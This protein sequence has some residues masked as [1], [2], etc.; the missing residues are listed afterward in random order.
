MA[1]LLKVQLFALVAAVCIASVAGLKCQVGNANK[2]TGGKTAIVSQT[3]AASEKTCTD[4][5]GKTTEFACFKSV[6][7]TSAAGK[8]TTKVTTWACIDKKK[9]KNVKNG[10]GSATHGMTKGVCCLTDN[11]NN[12]KSENCTHGNDAATNLAS[13]MAVS[14]GLLFTY[15]MS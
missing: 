8:A 15:L 10:K 12:D 2:A 1:S 4:M 7:C 9:C 6:V 11:C 5:M 14:F 13:I 3:T